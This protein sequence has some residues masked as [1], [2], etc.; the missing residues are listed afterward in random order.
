M[1][2]QWEIVNVSDLVPGFVP[3]LASTVG[4][5]MSSISTILGVAA[6]LMGTAK[7]FLLDVT[8]PLAAVVNSV[9]ASIEADINDFYNT[10]VYMTYTVPQR[11]TDKRGLA[12]NLRRIV[13]SFDNSRD[14]KRPTFGPSESVGGYI[15]AVGGPAQITS[16]EDVMRVL[17]AITDIKE[18]EEFLDLAN[19]AYQPEHV[20]WPNGAGTV[21]SFSSGKSPREYF[22]DL[23]RTEEVNRFTGWRM[24]FLSGLNKGLTTTI[25]GF[26]PSTRT[27]QISPLPRNLKEGDLYQLV[28]PQGG[29]P[30]LWQSKRVAEIFPALGTI[31]AVLQALTH[32][33]AAGVAVTQAAEDF[34]T[35]IQNKALQLQKISDDLAAQI[36]ELEA[37][38][39]GKAL[40]IL[41]LPPEA[42][43]VDHLATRILNASQAPAWGDGTHYTAVVA[44]VADDVSYATLEL[45]YG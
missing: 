34:I 19:P 15:L 36:A 44:L 18:I 5:T 40:Y 2:D 30:P 37:L 35:A 20:P 9:I 25:V 41:R 7:T 10:G 23:A 6:T 43:G 39:S 27:F 8:D 29:R 45:I 38:L 32:Q 11:L 26:D 17:K 1:A 21:T 14:P 4:G 24:D 13:N 16:V 22:V 42:G 28:M 33:L 31:F 12:N 3:T